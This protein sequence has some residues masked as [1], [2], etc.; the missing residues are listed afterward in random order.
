MTRHTPM[1]VQI[2][3]LRIACLLGDDPAHTLCRR[4]IPVRVTEAHVTVPT[5]CRC[6]S[7]RFAGHGPDAEVR[8]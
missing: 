7:L 4:L 2:P 3:G 8:L 5:C 6:A 1:R